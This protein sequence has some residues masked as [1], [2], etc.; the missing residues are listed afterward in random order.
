MDG[1]QP[2]Q[3]TLPTCVNGHRMLVGSTTCP[4][5]SAPV[6]RST[7]APNRRTDD[8]G[9]TVVDKVDA[10]ARERG[11]YDTDR[12]PGR[13]VAAVAVVLVLL[14]GGIAAMA[15]AAN[16]RDEPEPTLPPFTPPVVQTC[17]TLGLDE[18]P[19]DAVV[20]NAPATACF[21]VD[22]ELQ[23]TIGAQPDDKNVNLELRLTKAD[24]GFIAGADDTFGNVPEVTTDLVP[25]VY[26]ATVTQVGGTEPGTYT[27]Y[28]T[29]FDPG[30]TAGP[31]DPPVE[32]GGL[33]GTENCDTDEY[34]LVTDNGTVDRTAANTLVCIDITK[35]AWTRI[36]V[37]SLADVKVGEAP[38]DLVLALHRFDD[39]G[40]PRFVRSF[41][42]AFGTD[43][44]VTAKLA[45]GR[46][47]VQVEEFQGGSTG[48]TEIYVD[49]SRT[50]FR[51]GPV[52]EG[53][54]GVSAADCSAEGVRE[55][56]IGGVL[57]FEDS[58]ISYTCMTLSK[59]TL[60]DLNVLS[61]A[62]QDLALEVIGFDKD[63]APL[64]YGWSDDF[65]FATEF[66]NKNPRLQTVLPAG[67]YYVHVYELFGDP[68]GNFTIEASRP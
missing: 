52:T 2:P 60:V 12:Q 4:V 32:A 28:S 29:I 6:K 56:T 9:R 33:P 20:P 27:L 16:A 50:Y 37:I 48:P 34:P 1:D 54:E 45:P 62:Q 38:P 31:T 7:V 5:C 24:G 21:T 68:V 26:V 43:P 14:G 36:G 49:T 61:L 18:V 58:D 10:A 41:D 19:I 53:Y 30:A 13:I 11:E 22:T 57:G 25:G 46:Y 65:V 39:T 23:L 63:G 15:L 51:V 59:T 40:R 44:E 3:P 8:A 35:E 42:D 64:R 55:L 67:T 47:L 66:D 17:E